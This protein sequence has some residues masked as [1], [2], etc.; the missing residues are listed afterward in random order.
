M[1]NQSA[2]EYQSAKFGEK[3]IKVLDQREWNSIPKRELVILLLH[4]SDNAGVID[5]NQSRIGLSSRLMIPPT[6]LDSLIRDR[7]LLL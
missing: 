5:L 2:I 7:V 3:L 6:T 4:L 1:P